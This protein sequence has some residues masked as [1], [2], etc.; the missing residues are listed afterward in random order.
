M[1][2]DLD[3]PEGPIWNLLVRYRGIVYPT[4]RMT[5]MELASG[6]QM[7]GDKPFKP[8]PMRRLIGSLFVAKD[9]PDVDAMPVE[10]LLALFVAATGEYFR[11][12]TAASLAAV[13]AKKFGGGD[14]V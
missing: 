9:K 11:I 1:T 13:N 5:Y 3:N 12:A 7:T 14:Q 10:L 6:Q 8:A 4:R 2:I